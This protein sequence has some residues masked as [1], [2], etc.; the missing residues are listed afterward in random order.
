VI[1]DA[2]RL[3]M[4]DRGFLPERP[5]GGNRHHR[6]SWVREEFRKE[7]CSIGPD[8]IWCRWNLGA[9]RDERLAD[10]LPDT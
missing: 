7:V 9:R 6:T 3:L 8:H 1:S 2:V 5:L 4:K 10:S